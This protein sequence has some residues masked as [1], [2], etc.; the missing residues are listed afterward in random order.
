M[1]NPLIPMLPPEKRQKPVRESEEAYIQMYGHSV[2]S[3]SPRPSMGLFL[4]RLLIRMGQK[5]T[6]EEFPLESSR[7]NA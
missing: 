4:G 1:M 6:K 7:E 3:A 2:D 5:L